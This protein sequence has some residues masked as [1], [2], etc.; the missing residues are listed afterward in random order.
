M[1]FEEWGKIDELLGRMGMALVPIKH[2]SRTRNLGEKISSRKGARELKN[3]KCGI[4]YE[5]ERGESHKW[6][7]DLS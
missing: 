3:L 1:E 5:G 4:N 6:G 2:K 7:V